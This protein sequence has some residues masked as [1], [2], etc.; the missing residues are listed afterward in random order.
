MENTNKILRLKLGGR[1]VIILG[2]NSRLMHICMTYI[3]T[4]FV[5][6]AKFFKILWEEINIKQYI[7]NV[8]PKLHAPI[9]T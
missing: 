2:N 5:K 9:S 3:H 4:L 7:I 1:E 8:T 6:L